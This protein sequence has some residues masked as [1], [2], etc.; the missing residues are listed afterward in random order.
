MNECNQGN[1]KLL[2]WDL[3]LLN[4]P[5]A[6]EEEIL[7]FFEKLPITT[8]SASTTWS[9]TTASSPETSARTRFV[10]DQEWSIAS[11]D[12]KETLIKDFR[13]E[14]ARNCLLKYV[15]GDKW[16]VVTTTV[17]SEFS[18]IT[19]VLPTNYSAIETTTSFTILPLTVLPIRVPVFVNAAFN[20]NGNIILI[21]LL[22]KVTIH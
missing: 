14:N 21:L 12:V 15:Y 5:S 13:F 2:G 9:A 18:M 6:A 19:T 7:E 22:T 8:T 20:I 3:K 1:I 10:P 11:I 4:D 16:N 17:L